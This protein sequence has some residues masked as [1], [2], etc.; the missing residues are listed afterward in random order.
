MSA[1]TRL[2]PRRAHHSRTCHSAATSAAWIGSTRAGGLSVAYPRQLWPPLTHRRQTG[3]ASSHLTLRELHHVRNQQAAGIKRGVC[4]RA[5]DIKLVGSRSGQVYAP[6][7]EA[8]G[9]GPWRPLLLSDGARL[10]HLALVVVC[11]LLIRDEARPWQ[12]GRWRR[13]SRGDLR[14]GLKWRHFSPLSVDGDPPRCGDEL[15]CRCGE[16]SHTKTP[17]QL[18]IKLR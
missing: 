6:A 15:Q 17:F 4:L 2:P 10:E 3:L 16:G 11:L 7:G 13:C 18:L 5:P 12:D 1:E 8:A 9:A 14:L